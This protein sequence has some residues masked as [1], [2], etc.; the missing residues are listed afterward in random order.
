MALDQVVVLTGP[1]GSGKTYIS[2]CFRQRGWQVA[3]ADV[4]GHD[5]LNSPLVVAAIRKHWPSAASASGVD[6]NRLAE[7][8]FAE[9]SELLRLEE[10]THPLI[11]E[12][13]RRWLANTHGPRAVE[14]SVLK[15]IPT[16]WRPVVVI[17]ATHETRSERLVRRGMRQRDIELRMRVQ[18]PRAVWLAAAEILLVNEAP[19]IFA[20]ER[21]IDH[22]EA[23]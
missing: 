22:L 1:I 18:P 11:M 13:I 15:V 6:R 10:L 20:A 19:G 5:V 7:I 12:R 14:I 16:A 17:D 23:S 4:E 8:V 21:L 9:E 3:D 2:D